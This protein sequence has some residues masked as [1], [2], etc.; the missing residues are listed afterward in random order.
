MRSVQLSGKLSSAV[1]EVDIAARQIL[2]N[3][4]S[5]I[6]LTPGGHDGFRRIWTLAPQFFSL[7]IDKKSTCAV[8]DRPFDGF[9]ERGKE[10]ADRVE[11]PDLNEAFL[12]RISSIGAFDAHQ[13][14]PARALHYAMLCAACELEPFLSELAGNL[15][16]EIAGL[17]ADVDGFY[18]ASHIQVN[19]YR[20]SQEERDYLQDPHED[21]TFFTALVTDSPGLELKNEDDQFIPAEVQDGTILVMAGEICTLMTG[22]LIK[23]VEHRVRRTANIQSRMSAMYFANP[24]PNGL[25][26]EPWIATKLNEG[27]DILERA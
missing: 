27:V 24:N 5:F 17:L 22:G 16:R 11:R 25:R 20:P 10:Y 23:P 15:R 14:A 12:A 21:G 2:N 3:G 8:E 7:P 4:Y 19:W 1:G 26:L 9:Q 6:P 13:I 18:R